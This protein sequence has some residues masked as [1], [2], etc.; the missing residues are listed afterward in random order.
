MFPDNHRHMILSILQCELPIKLIQ[1][2]G[3]ETK[4]PNIAK[5]RM[6]ITIRLSPQ[7]IFSI[8]FN[9]SKLSI[10]PA[11]VSIVSYTDDCS[12]NATNVSLNEVVNAKVYD[13][14]A[15][16]NNYFLLRNLTLSQ[17]SHPCH[18]SLSGF[19]VYIRN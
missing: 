12:T 18:F 15:T 19:Q 16:I 6:G 9:L 17:T 1:K 5:Y 4:N 10:A 3:F 7:C 8:F 13:N 2:K 14:L 11:D